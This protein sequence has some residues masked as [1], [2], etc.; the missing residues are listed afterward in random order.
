MMVKRHFGSGI[1][2]SLGK[3]LPFGGSSKQGGLRHF[4]RVLPGKT[5]RK[6]PYNDV[7]PFPAAKTLYKRQ[8]VRANAGF[9]EKPQRN[10]GRSGRPFFRRQKPQKI[11]PIK[12]AA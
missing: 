9:I 6:S 8:A 1:S 11:C 5:R 7:P 10:T 3:P 2:A 4:T 12:I